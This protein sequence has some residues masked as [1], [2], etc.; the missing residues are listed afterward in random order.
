MR[1]NC[2]SGSARGASGNRGP[3][4]RGDWNAMPTYQNDHPASSLG[5]PSEPTRVKTFANFF[6]NYMSISAVVAAA[7]PIPV[8]SFH[9]I[10]TYHAQTSLLATY[11]SLFC[12]L[13]LGLIFYSRHTLARVMFPE[14][15]GRSLRI[16]GHL[17][18]LDS[19]ARL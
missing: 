12:F 2:T 14:F 15:F 8:T 1:E 17:L 10:P 9:L 19:E 3:T 11:T 5:G 7:L 6:K 16:P 13:L 4:V 18:S